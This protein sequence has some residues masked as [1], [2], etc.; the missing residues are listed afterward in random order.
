M[1][2]QPLKK[3]GHPEDVGRAVAFLADDRRAG[4]ATGTEIDIDGALSL[5]PHC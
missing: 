2:F 5:V 4:F 1:D 3:A